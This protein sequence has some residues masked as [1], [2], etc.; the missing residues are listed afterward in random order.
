MSETDRKLFESIL[1]DEKL[2]AVKSALEKDH[3]I[4]CLML[5]YF[6][7]GR[8]GPAKEFIKAH[9]GTISDGTFRARMMEFEQLGIATSIKLDPLKRYYVKTEF[10]EKC[11]KLMLST[12]NQITK[13]VEKVPA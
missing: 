11:A 8:W 13:A 4:T 10:G 2:S 5:L 3:A 12:F 1:T 7:L 9:K 6:S